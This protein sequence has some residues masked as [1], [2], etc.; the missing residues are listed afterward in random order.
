MGNYNTLGERIKKVRQKAGKSQTQLAE[1]LNCTQAA[2]SQYE[3]GAR[4]PGLSDL[5][6]LAN[7]LNTSTD[8]LLGRT[9]VIS[10]DI[11]VKKIGDYLGLSDESIHH[12]HEMYV[13]RK[14]NTDE[15]FI[16]KEVESFD[17]S[18]PGDDEF[19]SAYSFHRKYFQQ[20]LDDYVKALNQF[21]SSYEFSVLL[22]KLMDN[23][24][25]ER[26]IY[27]ILRVVVRRYDQIKAPL[28]AES[29]AEQAYVLVEESD[30]NIK[31]YQLNMF[32]IQNS[33]MDFCQNFTKLEAVKEAEHKNS[34]YRDA[35]FAVYFATHD[36]F[37]NKDF[38]TEI[39]EEEL[40]RTRE[41]I[42]SKIKDLLE[43][44]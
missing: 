37:L 5:V 21:I 16:L 12:L 33:V 41:R 28:F 17:G 15:A 43:R 4:E 22:S 7:K 20:D 14:R 40:E 36:M 44:I 34:L 26:Y 10:D 23:L 29:V 13:K 11:A 9:E 24:Y 25:L 1:E 30:N 2:L 39:M 38:S 18:V 27:D 32:E 3:K 19:A 8:Y 42:G 35:A 6:N 31:Q